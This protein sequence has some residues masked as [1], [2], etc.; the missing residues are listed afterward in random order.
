[1]EELLRRMDEQMRVRGL[2][3]GTRE[4][5][6][7][8]MR[9]LGE[10]HGRS[11]NELDERVGRSSARTSS[12]IDRARPGTRLMKPWRSSATIIW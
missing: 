10:F 5:Y 11:P 2:A 9:R 8:H 4:T 7:R 1:V 6:S 3:A 12:L